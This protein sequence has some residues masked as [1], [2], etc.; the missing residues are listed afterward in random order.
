MK[1]ERVEEVY[2]CCVTF[3]SVPCSE[4]HSF[5]DVML[6]LVTVSTARLQKV[7]C[8][9]ARLAHR[10][11]IVD[12]SR[13]KANIPTGCRHLYVNYKHLVI[14]TE[15]YWIKAIVYVFQLYCLERQVEIAHLRT[16]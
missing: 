4:F 16:K 12:Y 9:Q 3:A 15:N 8:S 6:V 14:G 13:R 2:Q 7:Q 10:G 1:Y 11:P 5:S